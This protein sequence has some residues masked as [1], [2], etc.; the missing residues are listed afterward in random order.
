MTQKKFNN[1]FFEE[2]NNL[3]NTRSR[4]KSKLNKVFNNLSKQK[5]E[6]LPKTKN[7]LPQALKNSPKIWVQKLQDLLESKVKTKQEEVVLQ[8]PIFWAKSITWT[9]MSGTVLGIVWLATAKTEEIVVVTGKL[10]PIQGVIEVQMPV[11]GITSEVLVKEG[12]RVKKGQAL[13]KLDTEMSE[14]RFNAQK[15][16][17]INSKQVLMKLKSLVDEGAVS[18]LQYLEQLNRVNQIESQVVENSVLLK[19]QAIN[20]PSD[21]MIF[22]LKPKGP[23]FVAR[24]T[25]PVLK[26]VPEDNLKAKIEI[27]SR[28]IGFVTAGKLVDISID[29][30]PSTDFGVISGVVERI[31][32]DALPP[33]P[34]QGLG[35]RYP[36]DIKLDTQYLKLKTGKKLKLPLQPGMS[37]TANVKLRK[38][39][40]LQLLLNNFTEK[41]ESLKQL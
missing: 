36:A 34:S 20:S 4:F 41:A 39:T 32:S 29:S 25:E 28:S 31:G 19:Y 33:V 38:V 37:L 3:S 21:G 35:Y 14:A 9:L 13:I 16:N 24:S 5:K 10:E 22:D 40:Y 12:Q 17:L 18:E 2:L 27:P 15:S 11:E 7:I 26:I 23:G 1:K 6:L 8:Q 30:F